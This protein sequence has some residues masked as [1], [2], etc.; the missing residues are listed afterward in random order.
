M[1]LKEALDEHLSWSG[2][3]KNSDQPLEKT[4]V[5]ISF[6]FP[7]YFFRLSHRLRVIPLL[8]RFLQ[9]VLA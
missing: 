8:L 3:I 9:A 7:N 4:R 2:R 6:L 5:S 1:S